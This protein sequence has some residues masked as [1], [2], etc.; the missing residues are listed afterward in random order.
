DSRG[1]PKVIAAPLDVCS[2]SQHFSI[3]AI[4]GEFGLPLHKK[5]DILPPPI[6]LIPVC[7]RRG[8]A[9]NAP[10]P[11]TLLTSFAPGA[12]AATDAVEKAG[13]AR[14]TNPK[15]LLGAYVV[16]L[17]KVP[18]IF[19]KVAEGILNEEHKKAAAALPPTSDP[20]DEVVILPDWD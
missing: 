10:R 6:T 14:W 3:S 16:D 4:G 2:A 8:V 1:R 5:K 12:Q 17:H 19:R 15:E 20:Y 11:T 7:S 18:G 13:R 9:L